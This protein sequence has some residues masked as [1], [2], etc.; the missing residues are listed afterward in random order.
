VMSR[1][2][3][4]PGTTLNRATTPPIMMIH[5]LCGIDASG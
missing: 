5:R 1:S 4:M 2:T 3:S